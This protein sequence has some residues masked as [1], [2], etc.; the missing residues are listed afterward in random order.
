MKLLCCK[1][2]NVVSVKGLI[3]ARASMRNFLRPRP[4]YRP[5]PVLSIMR[6]LS[7]SLKTQR[8]Y[9]NFCFLSGLFRS[10]N[11]VSFTDIKC[12]VTKLQCMEDCLAYF[13]VA[14]SPL[15]P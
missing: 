12:L 1:I 7:T 6:M 8:L 2:Y 14:K 13:C 9:S 4:F 3:T 5:H 11:I 10:L 15:A